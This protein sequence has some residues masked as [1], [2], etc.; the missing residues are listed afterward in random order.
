MQV[1]RVDDDGDDDEE[2][3]GEIKSSLA[4]RLN[5]RLPGFLRAE[6]QL[7]TSLWRH[8]AINDT[9]ANVQDTIIA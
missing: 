9:I 6:I 1:A 4:S 2:T 5:R 7:Q 3:E 8:T